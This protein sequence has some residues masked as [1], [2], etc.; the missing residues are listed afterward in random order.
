MLPTGIATFIKPAVPR[1]MTKTSC[2]I[3]SALCVWR[4]VYHSVQ[5][6]CDGDCTLSLSPRRRRCRR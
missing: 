4:A 2:I 3:A 5:C 1:S 6:L